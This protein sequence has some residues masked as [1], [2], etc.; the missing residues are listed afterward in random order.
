[1][2]IVNTPHL[3]VSFPQTGLIPGYVIIHVNGDITSVD[4][5]DQPARLS[6]ID[7]IATT[8]SSIKHI[9]SPERIYTLSIG[10]I[11]PALHFHLFPRTRSLLHAYLSTCG[12][13]ADSPVSGMHLFEWARQA[14]ETTPFE[15]YHAINE[16]LTAHLQ[17]ALT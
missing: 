14:Y 11:Q 16:Q 1:M 12:L 9:V 7:A 10:E 4:Q 8:H 5:L 13:N 2:T 3:T 17:S 15:N 6:L